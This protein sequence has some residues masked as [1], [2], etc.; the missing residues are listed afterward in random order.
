MSEIN[1]LVVFRL[2]GRRYALPLPSVERAVRAAEV[3]PL[4]KAPAIVLGVIDV[5]GQVLPVLNVR[6]RFRLPERE[7]TVDDQ[8]LIAR[9]GS[10]TVVLVVDVVE[11]IM[12]SPAAGRVA[13]AEIVPGLEQVEGVFKHADGLI[14]IHD[15]EKFLS[16]DEGQNLDE[17]LK[18]EA[19]HAVD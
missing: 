13:A 17:A 7:I 1:H 18:Q 10:R 6:K 5:G 14:L 11:G 9:A 12:D 15:L 19:A 3:T 2:E 8:F 16:L 4:P